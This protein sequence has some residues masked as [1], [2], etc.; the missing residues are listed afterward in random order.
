MRLVGGSGG[1]SRREGGGG[2][3]AFM[4]YLLDLGV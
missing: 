2:K 4:G 3:G 1:G